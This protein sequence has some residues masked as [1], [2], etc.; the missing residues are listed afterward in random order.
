[1]N[2]TEIYN[3]MVGRDFIIAFNDNFR[4][5]N[6]TFLSILAALI[7]KVK[8]TDIKEFKVIDGVVSYTLE[9]E[10]EDGEEDNRTWIP[11]DNTA[12]GNI[13]GDLTDQ[14]DLANALNSKAA[15]ETVSE[16][17][18]IL[19][20]LNQDFT[21]LKSN[22]E[23]TEVV[24]NTNTN[25]IADL[26]D[27]NNTK[28]T[29]QDIKGIR[30]SDNKFQWTTDGITWDEMSTTTSISWGNLTGD[31]NLQLD[32]MALFNG[33]TG[34]LDDLSTD[35]T[36]LSNQVSSLDT[37]VD[38]LSDTVSALSDQLAADESSYTDRFNAIDSSFTSVGNSIGVVDDKVDA[39][40]ARVDSVEAD[41]TDIKDDISDLGD[42]DTRIDGKIDTHL[43]D[44][45]NPHG[46]TKA[47][48]GLGNVDNTADMDK[49]LSTAQKTYVDTEIQNNQPDLS[50]YITG[51]AE[52]S[53]L[54]VGTDFEY[55]QA[56]DK[57]GMLAFVLYN[58][59][60]SSIISSLVLECNTM[61]GY[62]TGVGD[63]YLENVSGGKYNGN[64]FTETFDSSGEA[65][66]TDIPEGRYVFNFFIDDNAGMNYVIG[67]GNYV[68]LN[69]EGN[70][71]INLLTA[72]S[73]PD[74]NLI[75][76]LVIWAE[77]GIT[78]DSFEM[79]DDS[80][81]VI[82]ELPNSLTEVP[83]TGYVYKLFTDQTVSPDP[84][85]V[86]GVM[87]G[88]YEITYSYDDN[89]TTITNTE[90]VTLTKDNLFTP[91]VLSKGGNN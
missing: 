32:L 36:S 29:S 91:I 79:T 61:A 15:A 53:K 87:L 50:P 40:D 54:F 86:K 16:M 28:V 74:Y 58:D 88:E 7:Y 73:T 42:E 56:G 89:G 83:K 57:T 63:I 37:D 66:I 5:T 59:W 60:R 18:N 30:V 81:R 80:G 2:F 84:D 1:M 19:S 77:N 12:W 82:T 6:Q 71:P 10:P 34:D 41:I 26:K 55:E 31:I 48:V 51:V 22:Y 70:D 72:L 64:T 4:T 44:T 67:N 45:N 68:A 65:I 90:T 20:T 39:V 17:N 25:D 47:Q 62:P 52:V 49:P 35:V 85:Y 24:V 33:L 9:D 43:A 46:V 11:V 78:V 23:D 3:G 13:M 27:A 8:S 75:D 14:T 38:T 76:T 69:I 21:T